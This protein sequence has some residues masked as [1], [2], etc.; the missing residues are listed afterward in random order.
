MEKFIGENLKTSPDH[1]ALKSEEIE[2][3]KGNF[4]SVKIEVEEQKEKK[5]GLDEWSLILIQWVIHFLLIV[6]DFHTR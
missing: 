1:E 3:N 6:M 2:K 4:S 5:L